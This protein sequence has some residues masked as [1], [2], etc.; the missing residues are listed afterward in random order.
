MPHSITRFLALATGPLL[1]YIVHSET[2]LV[3][4][5]H[6]QILTEIRR[7][8]DLLIMPAGCIPLSALMNCHWPQS[9]LYKSD[10]PP[11]V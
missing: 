7:D 8:A 1:N 4:P 10:D 2:G 5:L 9:A 11:H 3:R 6:H